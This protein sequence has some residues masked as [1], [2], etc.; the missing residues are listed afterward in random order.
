MS[1]KIPCSTGIYNPSN[2]SVISPE[3]YAQLFYRCILGVCASQGYMLN[4]CMKKSFLDDGLR[5]TV[6]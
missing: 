1:Q 2:T 5:I 3:T 4:G 6:I